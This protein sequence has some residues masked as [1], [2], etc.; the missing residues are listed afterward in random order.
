MKNKIYFLGNTKDFK[1]AENL[2]E[3][4]CED[5]DSDKKVA[6]FGEVIETDETFDAVATELGASVSE[7]VAE[8]VCTYSVGQSNADICGFN[9]QKRETSRSLELLSG[10]FMGRVNIPVD[11]KFTEASVLYCSAGFVAAGIPLSQVIKA[12]NAKI[13]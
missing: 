2:F 9:F 8:K 4:L 5:F 10:S 3:L 1:L 12:I 7:S 11:S 13:S 6:V